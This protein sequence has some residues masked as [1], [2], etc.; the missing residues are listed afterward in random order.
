[1]KVTFDIP[2]DSTSGPSPEKVEKRFVEPGLP[3]VPGGHA[4]TEAV[5]WKMGRNALQLDDE[6]TE[7]PAPLAINETGTS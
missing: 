3:L 4:M 2:D 7:E 6:L 5:V 1:M